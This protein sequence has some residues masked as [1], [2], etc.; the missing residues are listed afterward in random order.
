MAVS[1]DIAI[2]I[3]LFSIQLL[4]CFSGA[5]TL[6]KLLPL[7]LGGLLDV[8]CWVVL[9]LDSLWACFPYGT[10]LSAYILG[11]LILIWLAVALF[12]WLIYGI[13]KT[14]QKRKE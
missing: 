9:L 13:A 4:L 14:A 7:I 3:V 11:I 2:T 10:A 12:A 6:L 5:K 8:G 1:F